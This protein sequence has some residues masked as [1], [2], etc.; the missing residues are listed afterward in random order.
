[1][2]LNVM[3][4]NEIKTNDLRKK[5][6]KKSL[7]NHLPNQSS[8]IIEIIEIKYRTHCQMGCKEIAHVLLCFYIAGDFFFVYGVNLDNGWNLNYEGKL[9][10][11]I[12]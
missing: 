11:E 7:L 5:I 10:I 8:N 2:W 4:L 1:M 12:L 6:K 9:S 3:W